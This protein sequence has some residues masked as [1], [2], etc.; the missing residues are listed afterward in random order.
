MARRVRI[1]C[2]WSGVAVAI[3]LLPASIHIVNWTA[4][5]PVRVALLPPLW[6]LLP[7]V[8]VASIAG[9]A[10]SVL[11]VSQSA[12]DSGVR[13]EDALGPLALMWLW[14]IPYLPWIPDRAPALLVLAG[15]LRWCV[16][17]LAALGFAV[18][19]LFPRIHW[20]LTRLPGRRTVLTVSL[21]LYLGFGLWS[22]EA[23]GPGADEPHYLVITQSLL[24][25]RDLAIENNH[26]RGDYREY[27]GGDLRP[28]FL[29][30]GLNDVIYSIHA[31]GLP[32][33]LVPAYAIAGYRGAVVMVCVFGA[34]AALAIFDLAMLLSGPGTA[35]LTWAAVCLTVPFVPHS[36][37]IF[38][39]MPGA[40]LVAW[41]ALWLY[42][43]KPVRDRTWSWRGAA[44]AILPWLHTKFVILLA[45]AVG[46]LCLRLW[47]RPRAA[48]AL[49][50]PC[51]VSVLLWLGSF[52]ALYGVFDP[53]I[54]YGDFPKLY[55]LA[56][57]IPRGVLG[58]LFDQKFGLLMYAPVYAVAI[59][60][61]WL[62][63][64]RS[65][66]RLFAFALIASVVAFVAS[67][68]RMY[69][70]WGGS[71]APARFLVPILPL[72][73][74]MIAVAFQALRSTSARVMAAM[75]LIVS[76]AIAAAGVVSPRRFMLFSA[77]HGLANMV[78]AGEGPAP[79]AYLLPTFTED[80]IRSPLTLLAPWV[81]A[82]V[83]AALVIVV[84]ARAKNRNGSLTAA[85]IGLTVFIVSG[86]VLAGSPSPI[87]RQETAR[88][89]RLDLMRAYDGP[90]LHAYDYARGITIQEPELFAMSAIRLSRAGGDMTKDGARF[91]G[92]FDL[93]AG[94][95]TARVTA[96]DETAGDGGGVSVLL[97]NEVVIAEGRAG[98]N[99]P[100]AFDLPI[101][102]GVS[103]LSS[104]AA[105]ASLAQ[106]VE[107][108]AESIVP[109]RSRLLV[110][111]RA[112]E[113]IRARPGAFI[114]YAD[115]ESYP[116]GGVFWTQG[117]HESEVY[118]AAAGAS[119][120]ALTLHV[121]P[122]D[123]TVR[124]LVDGADHSVTLSHDQTR[125]L[126]IPLAPR[127]GLVSLVVRAPGS[128][129]PSD[130]EPGSTDRRWLGCQVRVELQ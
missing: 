83:I 93:P 36:W 112:I 72:F 69:M 130:H 106:E 98:K 109:R 94:R 88:R 31:P 29:R 34:L 100:I 16:P 128:F 26:A 96:R 51:I 13:Y 59:A 91:A 68:T 24:R 12:P 54:P 49:V 119:T 97:G 55:V 111:P 118:V 47:R 15:P 117:T 80:V 101:D 7:A 17:L 50:V 62:M 103:L 21:A 66:A 104:D 30:R 4:D 38:P 78:V 35:W 70:W 40:L 41:A 105:T 60:G 84:T 53:Q 86:A 10:F 5:G 114:A 102:A 42:A 9:V 20:P 126:E 99:R 87:G 67:S 76:L 43:P 37:L 81:V 65:D 23:V 129:R 116:E 14:A 48:A 79:L 25:D 92:P 27:F 45:A 90:T 32:A 2:V 44:L 8:I 33:L 71:S 108:A 107:I 123:G 56:A 77:P 46:A 19:F 61:C 73:A 39:E 22:A 115:D 85:A 75:L 58:L 110:Q 3:W 52:Y 95:F 64:R 127:R 1:L 89:G 18:A 124:V 122:V 120:L 74:P 11:S 63:L 125:R 6:H 28:D 113:A 121:G 57:N 82:A